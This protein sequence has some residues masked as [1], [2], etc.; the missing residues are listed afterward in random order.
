MN[1]T[2]SN[3]YPV[4]PPPTHVL[5]DHAYYNL[6]LHSFNFYLDHSLQVKF[7]YIYLVIFDKYVNTLGQ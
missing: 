1:L 4:T 5:G 2:M 7:R 6:I 3:T